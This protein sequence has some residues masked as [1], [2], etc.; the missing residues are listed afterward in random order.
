MFRNV[1]VGVDRHGGRDAVAL[2]TRLLAADGAL[3]LAHVY[4]GHHSVW[5]GAPAY[6]ARERERAFD[7]LEDVRTGAGVHAN[8]RWRESVSVGHG[9]HEL[10]ELTAADLLVVGNTRR[11][12]V[13]RVLVA[14]DTQ[15][16]LNGALCATAVAPAGFC[17][18][19]VAMREIGVAYD[20][21][22]ESLH[23]VAVARELAEELGATLSAFEAVSLPAATFLGGPAPIDDAIEQLLD[24]A[25]EQ[26]EALEG[27]EA[28]AVYGDPVQELTLYSASLD[29]LVVGSRGQGPLARLVHGSTS[30]QLARTA[31]CPLLV[32]PGPAPIVVESEAR[33]HELST[34]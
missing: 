10:C 26:V 12:A 11:G 29:L 2:A 13:G 28:H 4:P 16:S 25:Q 5:R 17:E 18:Q 9:L 34:A 24:E 8:V 23:A 32:L 21:S 3:T 31:R 27:V 14:D 1:I 6:E 30:Q 22:P 33:A 19:A 20:G 15:G 7:L